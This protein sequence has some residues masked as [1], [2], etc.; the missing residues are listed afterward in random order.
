MDGGLLDQ[1][2]P[3]D[4]RVLLSKMVRRSFR[5]SDT[6][7][8]EGDLGDTIH[9]IEKGHV[10]IRTSTHN[11]DV[12]TLT[13]LGP[14]ASFGE[15]ALLSE[16]ATRTA[17]AVALDAVETRA[18][19]RNDF[20]ALRATSPTVDRFLVDALAGQV[21]RLSSQLLEALYISADQRV[22]RRLADVANIY[23]SGDRRVEVPI[24]QDDLA[25]MAGTTRPTANRV[26]KHLEVTGLIELRRGQIVVRDT[27]A[28]RTHAR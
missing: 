16:H 20:D 28:L 22:V 14:G 7:F 21:R 17:S 23:Q 15:Q 25:S 9:V 3:D 26:L 13:V 5:K 6:L 4:R 27:E 11:G 1:L 18:L 12:A 10:A 19:H 2:Q 24:R 8:H